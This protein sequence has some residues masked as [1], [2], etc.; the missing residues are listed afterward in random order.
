MSSNKK[1][2]ADILQTEDKDLLEAEISIPR[3]MPPASSSK[4]LT[5]KKAY[6]PEPIYTIRTPFNVLGIPFHLCNIR[7]NIINNIF[8][9]CRMKSR[10]E[11]DYIFTNGISIE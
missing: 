9:T 2:K 3:I 1:A 6:K 5:I 7:F 4:A 10:I 8:A 11:F